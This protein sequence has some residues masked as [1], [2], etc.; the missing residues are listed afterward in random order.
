MSREHI[1]HSKHSFPTT[2]DNSIHG[3]HQIVNTEIRLIVFFAAED[4]DVHI[5]SKNKT[6]SCGSDHWLL[7]AKFRLKLKKV[8]KTTRPFRYDLKQISYDYTE[9]VMNRF[10]G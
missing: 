3:H 2:R 7:I 10:K 8:W 1:G 4:E 5:D 9:E 6:W